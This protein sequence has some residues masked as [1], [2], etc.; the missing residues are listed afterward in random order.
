MRMCRSYQYDA[1]A[2][3]IVGR[4]TENARSSSVTGRGAACRMRIASSTNPSPP[5]AHTVAPSGPTWFGIPSTGNAPDSRIGID[6]RRLHRALNGRLLRL[7]RPTNG[8]PARLKRDFFCGE[9]VDE[10][11]WRDDR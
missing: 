4:L 3:N 6:A 5:L 11:T 2:T 8:A 10:L 7:S 9:Y 1:T